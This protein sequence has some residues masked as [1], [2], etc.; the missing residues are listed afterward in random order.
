MSAKR[1]NDLAARASGAVLGLA[2]AL[3]IVVSARPAG[4]AAV[5]APASVGLSVNTGGAVAAA[6]ATPKPVIHAARIR[7]GRSVSGRFRLTN[8][9]GRT[10]EVGLRALPSSTGLEGVVH[11]RLTADRQLSNTT[12]EGLRK[13]PSDPVALRPGQTTEL[14]AAAW[15]EKGADTGY[16]GRHLGVVLAPVADP[17][18]SK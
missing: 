9:T 17:R 6:P 18:R 12:V 4:G 3:L 11:L 5:T 14:R 13:T 7:P 8:Q 16:A 2:I 15:I 10:M 1:R